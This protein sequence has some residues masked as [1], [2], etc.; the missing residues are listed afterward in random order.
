MWLNPRLKGNLF[1][2][3]KEVLKFNTST[4]IVELEDTH[5]CGVRGHT[6]PNCNKLHALKKNIDIAIESYRECDKKKLK[7]LDR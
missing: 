1:Q 6:R 4:T 5:D 7:G 2:S 3:L